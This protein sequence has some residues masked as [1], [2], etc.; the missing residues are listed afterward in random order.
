MT[1][2]S[3]SASPNSSAVEHRYDSPGQYQVI[4]TVTDTAGESSTATWSLN[5]A[6]GPAENGTSPPAAPSAPFP[7]L[8]VALAIADLVVAVALVGVLYRQRRA[9]D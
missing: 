1:G 6:L 9:R 8:P 4:V 5:V 7:V 2:A 3:G